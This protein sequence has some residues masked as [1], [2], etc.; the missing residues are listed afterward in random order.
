MITTISA[1]ILSAFAAQQAPVH[2]PFQYPRLV[3]FDNENVYGALSIVTEIGRAAPIK[4][5]AISRKGSAPFDVDQVRVV[6]SN[7]YDS[8]AD[9][10]VLIPKMA[11][12]DSV[13][14]LP[15]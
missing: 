6:A 14:Q 8:G 4:R 13:V 10:V 7:R 5:T 11:P 3:A 1:I 12:G 9:L 2:F 15:V